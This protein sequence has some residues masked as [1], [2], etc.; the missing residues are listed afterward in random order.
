MDRHVWRYSLLHNQK[1]IF[2]DCVIVKF[3]LVL[4]F[5]FTIDVYVIVHKLI[6]AKHLVKGYSRG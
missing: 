4:F 3:L 6:I 5:L 1:H 2:A